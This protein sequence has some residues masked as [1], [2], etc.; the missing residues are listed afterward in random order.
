MTA[1]ERVMEAIKGGPQLR[2]PFT[3]TLSLYGSRLIACPPG[4]YFRNPAHYVEGQEAVNDL[5]HPDII[6][7]PFVLAYEGA[8]FGSELH[9]PADCPPNIRKPSVKSGEA[10]LRISL[11]DLDSNEYLLFIRESVKR[12]AARFKNQTP[13][14]AVLTAPIDLPA[15]IMGFDTWI[16]TIICRPAEAKAILDLTTR[17][18]VAFANALLQDGAAFIAVPVM[19]S[20]PAIVYQK[21]VDDLMLPTLVA[22]FKQVKGPIVFHHGGNRIAHQ[23]SDFAGLPNVA[24]FALDN[25]DSF[26]EARSKLGGNRLL[27]GNLS[28]ISLSTATTEEI[29]KKTESILA[30]RRDDP[31][32]IFATSG[33]DVPLSTPPERIK[34]VAAL[35]KASEQCP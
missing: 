17:H 25:R 32:F 21:L 12:L 33:A 35:I 34:A 9:F 26:S 5:I 6:F 8:A 19:F 30:D 4:E 15:T 2:P 28:G 3:M 16:D 1:L 31:C 20:N 23:L 7:A 27:L 10:F 18:F 13:I 11:P 29:L 22:A 14:C 24:G